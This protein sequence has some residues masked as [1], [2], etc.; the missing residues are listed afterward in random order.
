MAKK[1]NLQLFIQS[2]NIGNN[3]FRQIRMHQQRVFGW[4]HFIYN[5]S[6]ISLVQWDNLFFIWHRHRGLSFHPFSVYSLI[7]HSVNYSHHPVK[8]RWFVNTHP[9]L[10]AL[11]YIYFSHWT[12]LDTQFSPILLVFSNCDFGWKFTFV[13]YCNF[14][15]AER[16]IIMGY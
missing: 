1:I 10:G 12:P 4:K 13:N 2:S 15:S 16:G 8:K 7:I 14:S 5:F 6:S 11:E 9:I 3:L